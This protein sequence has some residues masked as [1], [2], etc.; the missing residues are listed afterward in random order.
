MY[1]IKHFEESLIY[2]LKKCL[3]NKKFTPKMEKAWHH[4]F[5]SL[6]HF[7]LAGLD[8]EEKNEKLETQSKSESEETKKI[9]I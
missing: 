2:G 6:I 7:I 8:N 3:P 4:V 9:P 5:I 1:F